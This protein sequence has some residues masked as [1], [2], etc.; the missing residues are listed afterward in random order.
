MAGNESKELKVK[1]IIRFYQL[2]IR[3]EEELN[4]L[5]SGLLILV[6]FHIQ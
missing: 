4:S 5:I 2:N 6:E 3:G 1:I